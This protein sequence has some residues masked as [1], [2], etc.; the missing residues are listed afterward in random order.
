MAYEEHRLRFI[1][2][3]DVTADKGI[4]ALGDHWNAFFSNV[5]IAAVFEA[6]LT[7]QELTPALVK[8]S[9]VVLVRYEPN[10]YR[11]YTTE[12]SYLADLANHP[13]LLEAAAG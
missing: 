4:A 10:S 7:D 13:F 12:V 3:A 6:M 8:D 9:A 11:A 1:N 2:G 5:D